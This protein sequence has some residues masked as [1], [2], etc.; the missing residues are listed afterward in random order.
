MPTEE[1]RR[2]VIPG[3]SAPTLASLV[4]YCPHNLNLSKRLPE[5]ETI[6]GHTVQTSPRQGQAV[7]AIDGQSLT[8]A[9]I[10]AVLQYH[11]VSRED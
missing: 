4:R 9:G 1:K 3:A 5:T 8:A 11:T 2:A 6:L 7:T 10:A